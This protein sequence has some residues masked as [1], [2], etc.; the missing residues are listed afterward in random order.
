MNRYIAI[1]ILFFTA[2]F[3]S[4]DTKQKPTFNKRL[5]ESISNEQIDLPSH[6]SEI[7][8]FCK[9]QNNRILSLNANEFRDIYSKEFSNLDYK[10]FLT[11]L[12][13]QEIIIQYNTDKSFD[14]NKTVEDK[15]KRMD[16]DS[17]IDFYC[18]KVG[19]SE[20]TL[21]KNIPKSQKNSIF[22]FLFVHN[23]RT[24]FDEYGGVFIIKKI[25]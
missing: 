8:F 21:K 18:I 9:S 5:I 20:Y 7:V 16:I 14:I 24:T 12:L 25:E 2:S 6:Y 4:C 23:Y 19:K 1:L 22:Y 13:N 15:Y 3:I 10:L 17:F 11:R